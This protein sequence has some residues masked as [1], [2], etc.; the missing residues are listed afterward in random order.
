MWL[1]GKLYAMNVGKFSM[2]L[3]VFLLAVLI[4]QPVLSAGD[5]T[6]IIN[7]RTESNVTRVVLNQTSDLEKDPANENYNNGVRSLNIGDCEHAVSYFEQA[8]TQNLTMIKKT[9]ALLY[10]YRNE[11]YCLI[12]LK[13]YSDAVATADKGLLSYP[14]DPILWNNKGYAFY[15]LGRNDDALKAYTA[16]VSYDG[17][18]TNAYINQGNVLHEMGRYR[19]AITAYTRANETDPF[20]IAAADGLDAARRGDAESTRTMTIILAGIIVAAVALIVWYIKFRKPAE[21][22]P[23][24]KK[25]KAKKK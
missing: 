11:A 13:R 15:L 12:E 2:V 16:A 14:R 7:N 4:A 23:E 21:P 22:A 24:E 8:L 25:K 17:N 20:N 1:S 18:Y 19:D 6:D 5:V 10:L 3:G 9:D